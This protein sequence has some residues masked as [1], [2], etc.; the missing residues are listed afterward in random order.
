MHRPQLEA[1]AVTVRTQSRL[2]L[3]LAKQLQVVMEDIAAYEK[4]IQ[5]LFLTHKDHDIWSSLPRAGLPPGS[6][7]AFRMG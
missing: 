3:S 5:T 6:A 4:E 1:S 7:E 2:M